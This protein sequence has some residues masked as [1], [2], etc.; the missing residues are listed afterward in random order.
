V[1]AKE[2]EKAAE[3]IGYDEVVMLGYHDSGMPDSEANKNP[4]CFAQAPL[5]EAVD[6]LAVIIRRTRPQVI[7]TYGD[8]QQG[9]PHPD[10]LRVHEITQPAIDRAADPTWEDAS[11]EPWLVA[12][13]YYSMWSRKRILET[14]AKYEELGLESPYTK[15][16]LDRPWPEARL[17]TA[18]DITGFN[19]V[20]FDA[21]L[22]HATQ[23]DPNSPF[24]FGLPRDVAES[25]YPFD[26]YVRASSTVEV[27]EDPETD[28]FSGL[29]A[30]V[31][32]SS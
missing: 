15:E 1:R 10:H 7:V 9:Y 23:I 17:N 25:I 19:G 2:L 29:R 4:D 14:H 22:A 11:G 18:I 24:W 28:L 12:K 16:W 3:I 21:L 27:T 32:V 20:R 30:D 5:Q 26:D 31:N 13:V 8:E 6:R